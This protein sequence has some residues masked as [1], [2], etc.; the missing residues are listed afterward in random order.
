MAQTNQV[1]SWWGRHS[2]AIDRTDFWQV[3]PLKM[4]LASSPAK[5]SISWGHSTDFLDS[6][7]R[8]VPGAQL[9]LEQNI[10]AP[11]EVETVISAFNHAARSEVV[12]A[13]MLPD[14]PVVLRLVDPLHVLPGEEVTLYMVVPLF[15]RLEAAQSS[16]LISEIPTFRLSDTW[17]GPLSTLGGLCYASASP[18][19]LDLREVPLRA[20]CAITAITVKNSGIDSLKLDRLNIPLPRLS[21]FYSQRS[22]F[23]TDRMTLERNSDDEMANVKLD[24]QP[25]PEASPTQFVT[26]P[27]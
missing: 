11:P 1:S 4:W 19:Y 7:V 26:G 25:P 24:R 12:F 9:Q 17:F 15:I 14:R 2:L 8:S 21:L 22:G 16:K 20:H 18:A 6:H 13:P 3:G 5:L 10:V 23:W 27:R